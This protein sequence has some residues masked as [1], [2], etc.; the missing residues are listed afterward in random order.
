M[1]RCD[2]GFV[3]VEVE[4][5][6]IGVRL[7][8]GAG[9]I[10]ERLLGTGELIGSRPSASQWSP[11]EY[12]G[13]VRDVLL[14]L[15]DRVV[16]ALV[17]EN[18]TF[19]PLYREERVALGLYRRDRADNVAPELTMAANLFARTFAGLDAR[20]LERPCQYAYPTLATRSVLWMAQQ[21]LHEVE[22][23]ERDVAS[24]IDT[25]QRRTSATQK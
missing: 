14:H 3:W 19:K 15:R 8:E 18:P 16:I 24:G 2:C 9:R 20:Q 25:L 6:T 11:L 23:H 22:H 1:E 17:E 7:I 5:G 4:P 12:G 10:A 13:H 21:T